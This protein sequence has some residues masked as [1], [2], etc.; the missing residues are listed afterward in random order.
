M[1]DQPEGPRQAEF[2]RSTRLRSA[3][4]KA[5][6]PRGQIL[7]ASSEWWGPDGFTSPMCRMDF[8]QGGTALVSMAAPGFGEIY[9]TWSYTKIVPLQRIDF[10]SRF[11]DSDGTFLDPSAMGMPPIVPSRSAARSPVP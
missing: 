8:R 7:S 6:G 4:W 10:V 5:S 3:P 11:S 2:H 1:T 9:N